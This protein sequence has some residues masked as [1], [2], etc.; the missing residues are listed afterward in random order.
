MFS[1]DD[2]FNLLKKYS[3]KDVEFG[4]DLDYLCF[5][6]NASKEEFIKEI[7][8]YE[9]LQVI[10]KQERANEERF[11]LYFIYSKT[12]GRVYILRF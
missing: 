5:R 1:R 6:N 11:A 10:E 4:K 8:S 3:F 7:F 9:N 2:F 12:K